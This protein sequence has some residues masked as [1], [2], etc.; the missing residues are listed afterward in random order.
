MYYSVGCDCQPS[1]L[2]RKLGKRSKAGPLDWLDTDSLHC[3]EYFHDLVQNEFRDFI[4]D[5]VNGR[6]SRPSSKH[7]PYSCIKRIK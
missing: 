1:Y 3:L 4:T 6:F 2:L 7:Y 5:L